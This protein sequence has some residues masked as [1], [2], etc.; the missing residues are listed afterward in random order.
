VRHLVV[1]VPGIGGSVLAGPNGVVWDA[2]VGD[3]AGAVLRPQG[4]DL[5]SVPALTPVGLI[6]SR[7]LVPGWALVSGY[8]RLLASLAGLS[9]AVVDYGDP[10][11]RVPNATV[12]AFPYDF[13]RSVVWVAE[14]LAEEVAGRLRDL[15]GNGEG[16]VI[17]VAHS[18]GGLVARYWLGPLGGSRV[19]RAVITLGTPHRGAPKALRVL[20]NGFRK[21]PFVAGG[22]TAVIRGWPSV[23]ELVPV[24][25]CVWDD[26][27]NCA[28]YPHELP[29][30]W[31]AGRAK[32]AFGV[33]GEIA[34]AW[35]AMPR[36]GPEMVPMLG[37]SHPTFQSARWSGRLNVTKAPARWLEAPGWEN[38]LGDGTVPAVSAAPLEMSQ[39]Q[40]GVVRLRERHGPLSS[41]QEVFRLIEDYE[42]RGSTAT[43]RGDDAAP[44]ALGLDIEESYE[45]GE[46]IAIGATLRN[47]EPTDATKVWA[48]FRPAHAAKEAVEMERSGPE[49]YIGLAPAVDPGFCDVEVVATALAGA[50]ELRVADA[51]CVLTP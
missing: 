8:E 31:F 12:V 26:E 17:V 19:C 25:Q 3:V 18:M 2:G 24:Y 41:A 47:T 48:I 40:F 1:V 21:G 7:T 16:R 33:H 9:G 35:S 49:G 10:G 20:V 42:A 30:D 5:G 39:A 37:W 22:L 27:A 28:R 14:R 32:A 23:Y 44:A 29:I 46:Q 11:R 50:G 51:F 6:R 4:L 15:G 43:V 13:R 36:G 45:F 34:G 38:D